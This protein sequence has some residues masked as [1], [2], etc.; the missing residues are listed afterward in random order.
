M[1]NYW[2]PGGEVELLYLLW[3]SGAA[4]FWVG[5]LLAEI[6]GYPLKPTENL[7]AAVIVAA[8]QYALVRRLVWGRDLVGGVA[9]GFLPAY[10]GFYLQSRHWVSELF[11][12]GLLLSLA[13][14]NALLAQRWQQEWA[15]IAAGGTDQQLGAAP[16]GLVFTLV[17]ILLIGGLLLIWYFPATPLPGRWGVWVLAAAAIVNQEFIKRKFY[18]SWRGSMILAWTASAFGAGLSLWLLAV[19]YLRGQG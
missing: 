14:F 3:I 1:G 13:S 15:A 10:L 6:N 2:G 17:N 4:A 8:G 11:I 12:L 18:A 9:L 7:G 19:L 5:G 16:R